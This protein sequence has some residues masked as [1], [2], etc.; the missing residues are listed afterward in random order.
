MFSKNNLIHLHQ[1]NNEICILTLLYSDYL[2]E[3][4]YLN[5]INSLFNNFYQ[6]KVLL[7][8]FSI[9]VI[10]KI[11]IFYNIYENLN[12]DKLNKLLDN[13]ELL[14]NS[15]VSYLSFNNKISKSL[16]PTSLPSNFNSLGNKNLEIL[17]S[18]LK[19]SNYK[20]FNLKENGVI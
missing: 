10:S 17:N 19:E 3:T 1:I 8:P 4:H 20:I 18:Y 5:L 16:K 6:K 15:S 13:Y 7:L 14:F 11:T 2:D 12:F 9:N